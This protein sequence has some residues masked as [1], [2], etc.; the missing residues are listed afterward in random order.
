MARPSPGA[1]A[2]AAALPHETAFSLKTFAPADTPAISPDGK[3]LAY[4]V[5]TPPLW[6]SERDLPLATA[7]LPN[8]TPQ[9]MVGIQLYLTDVATGETKLIGPTSHNS[10]RPSWSSDSRQIALFSD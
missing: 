2:T 6:S 9:P 5:C 1:G 7:Y 8:G 10:W 4:G 3:W